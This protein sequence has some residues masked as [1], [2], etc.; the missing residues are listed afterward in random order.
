[1][2]PEHHGTA[3]DAST[4]AYNLEIADLLSDFDEQEF[5]REE[6]ILDVL[7]T[8]N[9]ETTAVNSGKRLAAAHDDEVRG[10][11]LVSDCVI[12]SSSGLDWTLVKP[13]TEFPES[14]DGVNCFVAHR[15]SLSIET[16]FDGFDE[17]DAY[18]GRVYAVTG[19]NGVVMGD[20][21]AGFDRFALFKPGNSFAF[22]RVLCRS[23][24][25][26]LGMS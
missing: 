13:S 2:H 15:E 9:S 11:F 10:D 21:Q 22:Q 3:I 6:I 12:N 5:D 8:I 7:V 18:L 23:F 25:K 20:S 14:F 26:P 4:D 24:T 17:S 16:L 1:M 19:T